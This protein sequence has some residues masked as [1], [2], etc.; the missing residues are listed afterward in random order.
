MRRV[1]I[2]IGAV[3]LALAVAPVAYAVVTATVGNGTANT[4]GSATV[5]VTV[6]CPGGAKVIEAHLT[7]SQDDQFISGMGGIAG[8]RCNGRP[9]TYLV[10]VV[11]WDVDRAFHAGTAVASPYV[12]VERRGG[13]TTESGGTGGSITLE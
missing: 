10:R 2:V 5:P 1:L 7:L 12:L 13:K 11:P 9:S 8:V 3:G 6:S 4:D